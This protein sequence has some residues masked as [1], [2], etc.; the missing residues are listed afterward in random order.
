MGSNTPRLHEWLEQPARRESQTI[1][2]QNISFSAN[3]MTLGLPSVF[4]MTP[5]PDEAI[6]PA[7]DAKFTI[8]KMLK[9]SLRN[10]AISHPEK[11]RLPIAVLFQPKPNWGIW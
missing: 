7:G 11:I 1:P 3:W 2:L 5:N 10:S 8:L 4:R 9:N 6:D